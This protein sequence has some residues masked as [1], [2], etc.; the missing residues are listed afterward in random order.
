V[1]VSPVV[2]F[3]KQDNTKIKKV[4]SRYARTAAQENFKMNKG[5]RFVKSVV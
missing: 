3:A 2:K 1:P 5:N 4:F